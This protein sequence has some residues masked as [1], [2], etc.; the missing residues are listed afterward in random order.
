MAD[1]LS[2]LVWFKKA[3]FIII[4]TSLSALIST[5]TDDTA[6]IFPTTFCRSVFQTRV[7]VIRTH[8]SSVELHRDPEPLKD[9]LQTGL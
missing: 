8:V 5:A 6:R 1:L 4:T 9:T 3:F 2:L 7:G